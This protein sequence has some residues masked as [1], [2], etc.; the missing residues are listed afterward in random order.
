MGTHQG[1]CTPLLR[2]DPKK[3]TSRWCLLHPWPCWGQRGP[4]GA[5][6]ATHLLEERIERLGQCA[7]RMRPDDCQCFQSQANSRRQSRGC[8][9]RCTKTPA[10]GDNWGDLRGRQTQ[11][12]SPSPTRPWKHVTFQ[13]SESSS[14]EVSLMR[15]HVGQSPDRRKA[16]ECN[17]GSTPTL[18]PKLEYFLGEPALTWE[19]EGGATCCKNPLWRTMKSG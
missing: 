12:P 15:W 13:D 6:T 10:G 9:Q 2:Q 16:E 5:L 1:P 17:L 7:M 4:L 8:W 19:A 11:S 14:N 3:K 18:K